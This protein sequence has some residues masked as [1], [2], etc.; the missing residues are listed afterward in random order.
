M[1]RKVLNDSDFAEMLKESIED[2]REQLDVNIPMMK[3]FGKSEAEI[4]ERKYRIEKK[5]EI[6]ENFLKN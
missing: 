4:T 3:L 2:L 1:L 6:A 5:I